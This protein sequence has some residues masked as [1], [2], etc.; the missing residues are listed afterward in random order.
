MV[1]DGD[2]EPVRPGAHD[3]DLVHG[4]A[5]LEVDRPADLVLD[6]R[7]AAASGLEQAGDLDLLLVLVGL[8]PGRYQRDSRVVA[9]DQASFAADPVDPA[10]VGRAVDDLGLV[11]QV[12]D[13]ALVGRTALDDHR[14]LGDRPAQPAERLVAVAAGGDDLGDHRVEVGGDRVTLADAGVHADAGAGGQVSS[15][16]PARGGGEVAVGVLGVEPGLDGVA[17]LGRLVALEPAAGRDVDLQLDQVGVGGDLGDRVLDLEP[18]VDLEEREVL[19]AGLVEELDGA[20]AG[21]TR[22]RGPAARR[23]P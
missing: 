10:G 3:E 21:S 15:G 13:E 20:G 19:A 11:E 1:V 14:G 23:W 9:R 12:E 16:D 4:A 7:A 6:L 5:Q 2:P 17:A 18:G 8:D 22:P